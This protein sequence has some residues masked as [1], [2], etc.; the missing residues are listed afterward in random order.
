M[1]N[2][3]TVEVSERALTIETVLPLERNPT[4][5][6]LASLR[7][8]GRRSQKQALTAVAQLLSSGKLDAL[9]YP[10]HS[11]RYQHTSALR[12]A[13][14]E[15]NPATANKMLSALRRVL[16]EA[17]RLKLISPDDYAEAV[18]LK[19]IKA[20][21]LP[22]GRALKRGELSALLNACSL[23]PT[24]AGRRDAA[25][26]AV[27]YAAGLRRSEVVALD[28][29]DY[30]PESGALKVRSGKGRKDRVSYVESG[31][32][33]ALIDWLVVR[34]NSTGALFG[35][36]NK[37]GKLTVRRMA[38]QAVLRAVTKRSKEAGVVAFSPHDLRRTFISDLLDAGADI[39]TVQKLAGHSNVQ[40][41]ARYDR[42]GE[43]A[44]RRAAGLL[45]VPYLPKGS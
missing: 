10:W 40:T 22:R 26:L 19:S 45:H 23:D 31:T 24:P 35:P 14:L 2:Q 4:A 12:A 20:E 27:L 36:V 41:T 17:R 5:V 43:E 7:P 25:L 32:G 44:K 30:D 29:A 42:R 38:D 16:L 39:A 1:E 3:T 9:S 28:L 37:A 21:T 34:G 6:Y 33:A 18:D 8:T 13:L 15:R 11:L